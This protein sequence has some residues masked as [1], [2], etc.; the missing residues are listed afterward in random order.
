MGAFDMMGLLDIWNA[1]QRA[2]LGS[3]VIVALAMVL[4]QAMFWGEFE[5]Q[6]FSALAPASSLHHTFPSTDLFGFEMKS[7]V[8][9]ITVAM[10][11]GEWKNVHK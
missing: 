7:F 10:G 8:P 4:Q 11:V 3:T 5:F 1:V 9:C 2:L 6:T